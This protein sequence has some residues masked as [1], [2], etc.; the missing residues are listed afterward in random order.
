[1]FYELITGKNQEYLKLHLIDVMQKN[2]NFFVAKVAVA[3]FLK[4]Y[5]VRPA[6]YD[7]SRHV[8][9]ANSF[10][11]E[12]EYY[13]HLINED[14]LNLEKKDFQRDPIESRVNQI[15]KYLE[16]EEYAF[17]PNSII[18]NCDLINDYEEFNLDIN[19]SIEEF[20]NL[21]NVPKH[22]SYL[23]RNSQEYYLIVPYIENAILVIDGQHRVKGLEDSSSDVQNNYEIILTFIIGFD[24]SVIAKQFYTI[25]FEQKPVNKSLLI[26]LT[27]EFTREITEL[28]FMHNMVKILNELET[29]PFYKR[30]KMLG[31]IPKDLKDENVRQKMSISQA[32]LV[33]YLMKL[34]TKTNIR[35]IYLP[36]LLYYY[37]NESTQIN[38]IKIIA[39]YFN[40]VK[41]KKKDWD[42]PLISVI[43]KGMGVGAFIKIFHFLFPILYFDKYSK[44]FDK[45]VNITE[46]D[47]ESYLSGVENV[48]FTETGP[49][50]GVGSAGSINKIKEELVVNLDIF[51][52]KDYN[53]FELNF[54]KKYIPEFKQ[55]I[56]NLLTK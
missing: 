15:V 25:N 46:S 50:K 24:R 36:V 42:N 45:M 40:A 51:K 20:L 39:R 22:L 43:S 13:Q 55:T 7:L 1:M 9:F 16:N 12:E 26:Q 4:L 21:E 2:K 18:V 52:Y 19:N 32:F 44:N 14:K 34:I 3:D 56:T 23:H 11:D 37:I 38:I 8:E 17:F 47:F 48:D 29:S 10:K 5:T 54:K 33:E 6:K 27:G 35:G 49:F 53:E 28:S 30:I 41:K 31:K